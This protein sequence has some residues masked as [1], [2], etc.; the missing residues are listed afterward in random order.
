MT[1]DVTEEATAAEHEKTDIY[2]DAR[3]A[4]VEK[5]PVSDIKYE[6]TLYE[7]TYGSEIIVSDELSEPYYDGTAEK[8]KTVL[9]LGKEYTG[10]Y[11]NSNKRLNGD[12][13]DYYR[14]GENKTNWSFS[15]SRLNNILIS[16]TI[17][18]TIQIRTI[19]SESQLYDIAD[20]YISEYLNREDYVCEVY[21][22]CRVSVEGGIDRR[23]DYGFHVFA[24]NDLTPKYEIHLIRDYCGF[25][26]GDQMLVRISEDRIILR[27]Y[28]TVEEEGFFEKAA[29]LACQDEKIVREYIESNL[30]EGYEL[31]DLGQ[32]SNVLTNKDGKASVLARVTY[33]FRRKGDIQTDEDGSEILY[34]DVASIL[35][36]PVD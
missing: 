15:V 8:E 10:N 34:S 29:A 25:A 24:E 23:D 26:T 1:E 14:I 17:P 36:T 33:T 30:H 7:K 4:L 28:G 13:Y 3:N 6:T 16:Y 35:I 12:I 9:I 5:Y 32:I 21:T 22:K 2:E 18:T 20:P 31:V 19:Q 27:R 11:V